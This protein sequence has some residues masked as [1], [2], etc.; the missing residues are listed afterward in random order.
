MK[1]RITE[2]YDI[3][4]PQPETRQRIWDALEAEV[5]FPEPKGM[6][7]K[8]LILALAGALLSWGAVAAYQR[9]YLPE[10]ET[11]EPDPD[12]GIYQIQ[13]ET[14]YTPEDIPAETESLSDG[15]FLDQAVKVLEAVGLTD[16]D[17][18][19]M[20]LV[21][22]EHLVYGR[23]E[24]EVF[25]EDDA[26][27]TSVTFDASFGHLL[28]VSSID[29][30]EEAPE[31]QADPAELARRYY[32]A[33]PVEQ[34][35]VR[36]EEPERYDD[37]YWS[38]S[39][40]REVQPGLYSFYEMVRV[41]VNPVSG[42][43]VGCNVFRFPLLDDHGAGESPLSREEAIALAAGLEKVDVSGYVLESAEVAVVLPNWFF[44]EYMDADL[45]YSQISRLGWVLRYDKPN[46]EVSERVELWF[47]LYTGQLLGG[48][49]V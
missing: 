14:V 13:T 49:M 29:W 10:P 37:Q 15:Y 7:R 21:R 5:S 48:G 3:V 1:E 47:D 2:A 46:S 45:R 33:L 38:Y 43:L 19:R 34:G 44:T 26:L 41:A 18:S 32:E 35:Y 23:Q 36:M 28:S 6:G 17:R 25:F 30:L 4:R 11:Y 39:F 42:R 20:R 27:R 16:V 9:W 8:V 40:C 24:A 22:Q 12:T 31:T